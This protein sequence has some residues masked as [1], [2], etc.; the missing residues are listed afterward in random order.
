MYDVAEITRIRAPAFGPLLV[1]EYLD[2]R[3][4]IYRSRVP[5]HFEPVIEQVVLLVCLIRTFLDFFEFQII[6]ALLA[7][8]R[9]AYNPKLKTACLRIVFQHFFAE[10]QHVKVKNMRVAAFKPSMFREEV[11]QPHR[12]IAVIR[13]HIICADRIIRH[14]EAALN[15]VN[16]VRLRIGFQHVEKPVDF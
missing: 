7:Y 9:N 3:E 13:Q 4:V 6:A 15:D 1:R 14:D 10:A 5:A 11:R 8:L 2:E 12:E 16:E